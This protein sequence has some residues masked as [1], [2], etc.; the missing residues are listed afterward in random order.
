MTNVISLIMR[1]AVTIKVE[2]ALLGAAEKMVKE[3]FYE[4]KSDVFR[5]A[6]RR[7]V[8]YHQRIKAMERLNRMRGVLKGTN[9]KEQVSEEEREEIAEDIFRKKD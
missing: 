4:T 1:T 5:D 8:Q 6:L 7:L 3:G 9:I 2:G